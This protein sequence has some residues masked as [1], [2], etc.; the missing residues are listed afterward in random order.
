MGGSNPG[1]G[2]KGKTFGKIVLGIMIFL[3]LL[4]YIYHHPANQPPVLK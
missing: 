3:I 1:Y 4:I 2:P